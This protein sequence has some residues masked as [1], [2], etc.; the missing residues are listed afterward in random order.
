MKERGKNKHKRYIN[1][2]LSLV[3]RTNQNQ[4][5]NRSKAHHSNCKAP[6]NPVIHNG[7]SIDKIH[8]C[9]V[10]SIFVIGGVLW[11]HS[12]IFPRHQPNIGI[13]IVLVLAINSY[14]RV[15]VLGYLLYFVWLVGP[16]S[17][18]IRQANVCRDSLLIKIN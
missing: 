5:K 8:L 2:L 14:R 10:L 16:D 13:H 18:G 3:H 7:S 12:C 11:R 15:C 6:T 1:P 17:R 4:I 9:S